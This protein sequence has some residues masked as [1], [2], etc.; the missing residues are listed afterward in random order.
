M[1]GQINILIIYTNLNFFKRNIE[2]IYKNNDRNMAKLL[3]NLDKE[4]TA[5]CSSAS[6]CI[7]SPFNRSRIDSSSCSSSSFSSDEEDESTSEAYDT[8]FQ[9]I[10][11]GNLDLCK[12]VLTNS[13]TQININY[14]Y[15]R[16]QNYSFLHL[17]CLMGHSNIIKFLLDQGAKVKC[18]TFEGFQPIDFIESDD[19]NTI[20]YM[21]LK[22]N[23]SE[24]NGGI[25]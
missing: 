23:Q 2:Q 9:A 17:A 14:I 20:S 4:S 11:S 15:D 16:K 22:I 10:S 21:L 5:G 3:Q 25:N 18:E 8:L 6:I 19:L 13:G 12:Q 7:D 24:E 1:G